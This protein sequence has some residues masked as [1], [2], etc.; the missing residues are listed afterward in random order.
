MMFFAAANPGMEL[1]GFANY[2]KYHM[3]KQLDI[4]YVPTT[5]FLESLDIIHAY[6]AMKAHNLCFPIIAK[7]D[8]GERGFGV[9][10]LMNEE[11][12][13]QY[14]KS[15][16]Q[17]V[18]LQEYI[19]FPLELGVMYHKLPGEEK[20]HITSIVKKS[21]LTLR[22]DGKKTMKELLECDFRSQLQI[23][24]LSET[25]GTKINEVLP[26]EHIVEI[27]SIGNHC[28]G[29]TFLSAN[30]WISPQLE[31]VFDQIA[32]PVK[33]FC[34]GRFDLRV[35]SFADLCQGQNIKIMEVNGANSEPAHIY[36][37]ENKLYKAYRDLYKHWKILFEV[38][39]QNRKRGV[40][41]PP[42]W[43]GYKTVRSYFKSR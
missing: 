22:G 18:L 29:T 27:E 1:G 34:F 14:L 32:R 26:S 20:G 25:L 8:K 33:G 3:L 17:A 41:Y 38:S 5:I 15:Q 35:P 9:V 24:R 36:D 2:S 31:D 30:E 23:E 13:L 12:L 21:F 4:Q 39:E 40:H 10:K 43:S 11:A 6:R 37:P 42:V 28:R 16:K 19:D 7:P